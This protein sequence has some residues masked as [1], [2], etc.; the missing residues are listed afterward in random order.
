[1]DVYEEMRRKLMLSMLKAQLALREIERV[2]LT[3]EIERPDTSPERK[4]DAIARRD[5]TIIEW[6]EIMSE[7]ESSGDVSA[8]EIGTACRGSPA[9]YAHADST[10]VVQRW[11][12]EI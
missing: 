11:A 5:A 1:M 8:V 2:A 7:L 9:R 6:G 4:A 12:H 3:D 10:M